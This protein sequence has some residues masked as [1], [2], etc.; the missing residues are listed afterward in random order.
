MILA[1]RIA[2][3]VVLAQDAWLSCSSARPVEIVAAR[4]N[5]FPVDALEVIYVEHHD[6]TNG[7]AT[8]G[9]A[10]ARVQ[11]LQPCLR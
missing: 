11:C 9:P 6:P 4:V 3:D 10:A 2:A 5:Q 1:V 7:C 8:V